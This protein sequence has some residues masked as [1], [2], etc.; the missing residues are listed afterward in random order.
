MRFLRYQM[1]TAVA[2]IASACTNGQLSPE[3]EGGLE[4]LQPSRFTVCNTALI[5]DGL[6][7]ERYDFAMM[8]RE[9]EAEPE[10]A[11]LAGLD[12]VTSCEDARKVGEARMSIDPGPFVTDENI[13]ADYP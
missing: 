13:A 9:L 12:R 7:Y 1:L 3:A 11:R 10:V 5:N 2:C 6:R 8:T 4:R